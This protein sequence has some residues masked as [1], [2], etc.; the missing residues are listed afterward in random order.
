[1]ARNTKIVN[2][3]ARYFVKKTGFVVY[4]VRSSDGTSVYYT[5]LDT[6]GHATGC[7]CPARKPC[8]H[9]HQMEAREQARREVAAPVAEVTTP[10]E[11]VLAAAQSAMIALDQEQASKIAQA[12]GTFYEERFAAAIPTCDICGRDMKS[13][14]RVCGRCRGY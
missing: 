13:S 11:E 3:I 14:A 7:T 4:A 5:T 6:R 2:I 1:M 8:K 12:V 10:V 9:M